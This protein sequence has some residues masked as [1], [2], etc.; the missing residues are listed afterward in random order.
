V[1]A[2]DTTTRIGFIGTGNMGRP[3]AHRLLDA[4]H[5]LAVHDLRPE[6][7]D[8][9]V[10][11]G[12]DRRDGPAAVAADAD[13]V[14]LC[15][16]SHIEVEQVCL[17]AGGLFPAL[18]PGTVLVDLSTVSV[19]L[20]PRLV[21]AAADHDVRYLTCPV[22]Q[23]VDN[24]WRGRLSLFVGGA[25]ADVEHVRPV[26]TAI[27]TTV[28]HTGD[29]GT[30][31]AA[32]LLTNLLWFVNAAAIG[33][34]LVLGA[35]AGIDPAT[36]PDVVRN[37]CGDSWVAQHDFPSILAGTWDPTFSTR[38]C[39]KDLGLIGGLADRLDLRLDLH[40]LVAG[41][42]DRAAATYGPDSP[43]LSVVRWWQDTTGVRLQTSGSTE[44]ATT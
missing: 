42:F 43:E 23:G 21:Q 3:V 40:P 36:L 41:L 7:T 5:P 32:K 8:S 39:Q 33:E 13:L 20:I 30:A 12:A 22:S 38:L 4:G 17:G 35:A 16:P 37:S 25:P 1:T 6:A 24:A 28:L 27:A 9:L 29:H 15:L 34:A 26:L 11:A 19:D 2:V 10:A 18:R 14:F 31:M 44:P